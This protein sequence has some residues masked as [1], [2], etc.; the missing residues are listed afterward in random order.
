MLH[1][2]GHCLFFLVL[3]LLL[4]TSLAAAPPEDIEQ[5]LPPE[6]TMLSCLNAR[7]I[8]Q[9]ELFK[10]YVEKPLK[11]SLQ[12]PEAK[13]VLDSLEFD[14]LHDLESIVVGAAPDLRRFRGVCVV[15]G[16]FNPAKWLSFLQQILPPQGFPV[17]AVQHDRYTLLEIRN[18]PT[19]ITQRLY[20]C[21]LTE[22]RLLLSASPDALREA[23]DR[24]V[25]RVKSRLRNSVVSQALAEL[26]DSVSFTWFDE[27]PSLL[28]AM[29]L[30]PG[31]TKRLSAANSLGKVARS[32][33]ELSITADITLTITFRMEDEDA[34]Q[35]MRSAV[36]RILRQ[37][38]QFIGL[39]VAEEPRLDVLNAIAARLNAKVRGQDILIQAKLTQ[40]D[41]TALYELMSRPTPGTE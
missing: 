38:K 21:F 30:M 5:L 41:F 25:S 26:K 23:L 18:I 14:P 13:A 11:E 40:E 10:Q 35:E 7:Q 20:L 34:A 22:R 9:S 24:S 17:A 27:K 1:R 29:T 8:L 36:D 6:S 33:E 2:H 39:A 19:S 12:S 16:K 32:T 15:S 4:P 3:P 31:V 37:V 28:A